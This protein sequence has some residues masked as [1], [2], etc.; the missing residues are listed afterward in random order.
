MKKF[1][2]IELLVVIA[3]IA[4]LAGMLLPALNKARDKAKSAKCINNMKQLGTI[5]ALYAQDAEFEPPMRIADGASF[6]VWWHFMRDLNYAPALFRERYKTGMYKPATPPTD[7]MGVL[8]APL[9]AG[10]NNINDAN[11]KGGGWLPDAQLSGA[12]FGGY[13][14]NEF[15]GYLDGSMTPL[16]TVTGTKTANHPNPVTGSSNMVRPGGVKRPSEMVRIADANY[17]DITGYNS[18]FKVYGNFP[19]NDMMNILYVDGHTGSVRRA[20]PYNST[21]LQLQGEA[22]IWHPNGTW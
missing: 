20:G 7:E 12:H 1:T 16:R 9:C 15:L 8:T 21:P 22:M 14:Y 6:K 19:H 13:G 2:L 18:N 3:I 5:S 17:Y 10:W 11:A 4:I